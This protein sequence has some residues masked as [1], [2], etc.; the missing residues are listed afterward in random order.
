MT[1]FV[2]DLQAPLMCF[3]AHS[4]QWSWIIFLHQIIFGVELFTMHSSCWCSQNAI[5]GCCSDLEVYCSCCCS[6]NA[7]ATPARVLVMPSLSLEMLG[8]WWCSQNATVG[9]G[10][11]SLEVSCEPV[12]WDKLQ[13]FLLLILVR[14]ICR[15]NLWQK[16]GIR[17]IGKSFYKHKLTDRI[18]P[19][20]ILNGGTKFVTFIKPRFSSEH[21]PK[22]EHDLFV[23]SN[24]D[25]HPPGRCIRRLDGWVADFLTD[26]S[27]D[28]L[29]FSSGNLSFS[30]DN[31]SSISPESATKRWYPYYR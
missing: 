28:N 29:S 20:C 12:D 31:L 6:Q 22:S 16:D 24:H 10:L 1:R 4:C 7:I 8:P 21:N 17:I 15:L 11:E 13:I 9:H 27:S 14:T 2:R 30:S 26:F 25:H 3:C 19:Y 23:K 5:V 18:S